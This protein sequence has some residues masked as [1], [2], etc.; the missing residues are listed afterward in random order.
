MIQY[1][2]QILMENLCTKFHFIKDNRFAEISSYKVNLAPPLG[3][4]L[5]N[6]THVCK[7]TLC[8]TFPN[9]VTIRFSIEELLTIKYIMPRLQ[10][11]AN[12]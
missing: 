2:V 12:Q 7:V 6:V 9:L 11:F 4:I 3:K 1:V 8:T 5:W 10:N